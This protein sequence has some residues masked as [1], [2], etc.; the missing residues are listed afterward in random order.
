MGQLYVKKNG[1]FVPIYP[2]ALLQ[3]II[4][5][6]S[7]KSLADIIASYN[8]LYI[9]FVNNIYETLTAIPVI[10]RRKG[11]WVTYSQNGTSVTYQF[12]LSSAEAADDSLW[13]DLSYW[14]ETFPV[15]IADGSITLAKFAPQIIDALFEGG[16]LINNPD[17]E[18]LTQRNGLISI[19]NRAYDESHQVTKAY[20]IL[21]RDD[22]FA[23]QVTDTNTIY[24]IRY[25]FSLEMISV[26]IPEGCVLKFNGGCIKNGT[27]TGNN[28]I[29]QGLV[30]YENLTLAGTFRN[31]GTNVTRPT[32]N[33][34]IGEQRFDTTLGIPTWWNGTCWVDAN[35]IDLTNVSA[36]KG[37]T[38]TRIAMNE[39]LSAANEGLI[40][41]DEDLGY[42]VRYASNGWFDL[43]GNLVS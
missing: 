10:F 24:D 2:K 20:K 18:D 13:G 1:K 32:D 40:Y 21:R 28:T 15:N 8:H 25:D 5:K 36:I 37:N 41:F 39:I 12:K 19:K 26:N 35:G 29:V 4:D 27:I 7:G 34:V 3:S 43:V 23:N 22:S 42:P 31:Y 30:R 14:E 16:Q 38:L 33:L 6:Q 9:P 11:L 17:E